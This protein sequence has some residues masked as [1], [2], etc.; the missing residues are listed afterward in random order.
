MAYF[1]VNASGC[2]LPLLP[3]A[4]ASEP[5]ERLMPGRCVVAASTAVFERRLYVRVAAGYA[6]PSKT[7]DAECWLEVGDEVR[8][9][10][11][12][13]DAAGAAPCVDAA[14]RFYKAPRRAVRLFDAPAR[15]GTLVGEARRHECLRCRGDLVATANEMWAK[16]DDDAGERWVCVSERAAV[17]AGDAR[18]TELA[19]EPL[20]LTGYFVNCYGRH[21]KG[22]LPARSKP[23]LDAERVSALPPWVVFKASKIELV[24]PAGD[25]GAAVGL[26]WA[27]VC[28]SLEIRRADDDYEPWI[29]DGWVIHANANTGAVVLEPVAPPHFESQSFRNVYSRGALPLR[30]APGG[31][32]KV[33]EPTP[34]KAPVATPPATETKERPAEEDVPATPPPKEDD[35]ASAGSKWSARTE[36]WS[37]A[38]WASTVKASKRAAEVTAAASREAA[39]EASKAYAKAT[40]APEVVKTATSEAVARAPLGSV[41]RAS[42]VVLTPS[43]QVWAQIDADSESESDSDDEAAAAAPKPSAIEAA[44]AEILKDTEQPA[45]PVVAAPRRRRRRKKDPDA[46]PRWAICRGARDG[47]EILRPIAPADEAYRAVYRVLEASVLP[48]RE[49]RAPPERDAEPFGVGDV[50]VGAA[51]RK[52]PKGE[53]WIGLEGQPVRW[54]AE[55]VGGVRDSLEEVPGLSDVVA[56][57]AGAV[58]ESRRRHEAALEDARRRREAAQAPPPPP[59]EKP[60]SP[61]ALP[62]KSSRE[63]GSILE[64]LDGFAERV[65]DAATAE[66]L[67]KLATGDR[68]AG[69]ELLGE[70]PPARVHLDVTRRRKRGTCLR[71]G[72]VVVVA[73]V[74]CDEPSATHAHVLFADTAPSSSGRPFAERKARLEAQQSSPLHPA[75]AVKVASLEFDAR[76]TS[77]VVVRA[78]VVADDASVDC[79]EACFNLDDAAL[80]DD[81]SSATCFDR[82]LR[83]WRQRAPR[84]PSVPR[85][86]RSAAAKNRAEGYARVGNFEI[87]GD[88]DSDGDLL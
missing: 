5:V 44:V 24:P 12:A 28:A 34:R 18:D 65:E 53:M 8:R 30:C 73:V 50:H 85:G 87:G 14:T 52:G 72:R 9:F 55:S 31:G 2:P 83:T 69:A 22:E 35:D 45:A 49:P 74:S 58:A 59:P 32:F 26:L 84:V 54:V 23:R 37:K 57:S 3:Y 79:G 61:L 7:L 36:A 4:G 39:R 63:R 47:A 60:R 62:T 77:G 38:A 82:V 27:R 70:R 40:A 75:S 17:D 11:L 78:S 46:E 16:L 10:A 86:P 13:P 19:V 43:G 6:G 71:P 64:S 51:R 68:G 25:A 41:L 20:A 42:S 66:G 81:G 76:L 48:R 33:V 80:F 21:Y 67:R 56:L 29:V 88:D 15:S 1:W